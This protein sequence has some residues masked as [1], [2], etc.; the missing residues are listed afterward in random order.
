MGGIGESA[1]SEGVGGEKIA[2]LVMRLGLGNFEQREERKEEYY[3]LLILATLGAAVLVII[4]GRQL[5][6]SP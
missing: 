3:I 1:M 5:L 6:P 2:E 4:Y